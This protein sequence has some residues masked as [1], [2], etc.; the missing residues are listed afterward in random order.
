MQINVILTTV[1]LKY[2]GCNVTKITTSYSLGS[3]LLRK[4][5]HKLFMS[6]SNTGKHEHTEDIVQIV[7]V[8]IDRNGD[9]VSRQSGGI[10]TGELV[11]RRYF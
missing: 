10:K 4:G 6:V 11:P 5:A 2:P 9:K 3:C 8:F 1:M 7:K